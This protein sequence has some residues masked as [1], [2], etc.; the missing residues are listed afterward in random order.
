MKF[1]HQLKF[2]SVP[3]WREHYINYTHLKKYIYAL[4][5]KEADL[6][7]GGQLT[8]EENL[9]SP[10]LQ[11]ATRAEQGPTEEGFQREL[12][13]Q[14][15]AILSFFA[16]KE[17][18]LLAK[19]SELELDVQSLEK[20]PNR[21]EASLLSRLGSEPPPGTP[22]GGAAPG[23][24]LAA[25]PSTLDLARMVAT[26][27]PEE[28]R[29]VRVKFWEN[30]P[31]HVFSTSSLHARRAKLQGRFQD[32]YISLHDLREYLHINKEGFRKI[33]KKHDKLTRSVDLRARWWPNVEAHLAP[34]T[35]QQ[36]LD[37]AIAALTDHYAVLYMG[38]DVSRASE[39]LSHGLREHITVERNTVWRDMAAMER[40]Y[41][42][43]SVKQAAGAAGAGRSSY[44][45]WLKLAASCLVFALLLHVEV[46][47]GEANRPRNNCLALLVFASMLWSLEAVPLFV[48]SMGL[49]LLIVCLGVLVEP[50]G[51]GQRMTPQQA[52]PAIF[53][54]MF[55]QTI[56][57]LLGGF[58]IAAALSKHAIAKQAAVA[59]LS[60]VGR[61][62]AH[63]LLAAMFT[64][65]FASMWI[66]NV[67][68]PV[69]C[70]G[71]IQPILRTLDPG[72]PF[73]KALVMGIALASN[74]GGMTSPISSPQ[75]IFAIERMSMDGRPP[76]WLAWFAVA[77]PVS[78]ACNF[79]CWF[80]L[81]RVYQ[82]GRAIAE[83]RPIKPN[84]DPVNGTQVYIVVVSLLTVAAWCANT[85]LQRYTGEMGVIAVVPL[86]AF[87]GFDV[88]NKDDF[89]SFLWN[90]VMLA[91]GGLSLGEAVKSS[92]L[93]EALAHDISDLVTGLSLWQ[94]ALIFS[95]LVLVATTFISHTVGAMVIL[96]IVQSVGEAMAGGHPHPKLLVM[97]AALMCS[98]AMGLPVS[99]FPNMNAV[100]IE[101]ATGNAIVNTADFLRVGVPSSIAAYGI[102][103]SVGYVL[104]LAVGF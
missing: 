99:G 70:F 23:G 57:L 35:K 31:R 11:D 93:L 69:L 96:P 42:A 28:H 14:L 60:R 54:A 86:V 91:M 3:E 51:S 52:A 72:H 97:A 84:T 71:L 19:V 6:Q 18:D 100:S 24:P 59:I 33:I 55:S 12:D 30:P 77:L 61:K 79:L 29:R 85:F 8:D 78:I 38:G 67:A 40:K 81:L 63:V 90:V 49:P 83:V 10:L 80:L 76:S 43:V 15:A 34:A 94:V 87:F 13:V 103:V 9:Y 5:K 101:D 89:N 47:P 50:G 7:A 27:P 56:M 1:T 82:P 25:S 102:I 39:E 92:G 26:T 95:G 73:A 44:I 4:A 36:E 88:L 32:L 46:W 58:A 68:A 74:V 37:R 64:A 16:V 48:T 20:I 66:S 2:N 53:H 45:R 62:P 98:G 104:M 21:Q 22:Q 41:A 65:T 75:N 17:A